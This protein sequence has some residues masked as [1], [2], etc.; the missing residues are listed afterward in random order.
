MT[1]PSA[2]CR[3]GEILKTQKGDF[4]LPSGPSRLRFFTSFRVDFEVIF[5]GLEWF[6]VL[7]GRALFQIFQH[8]LEILWS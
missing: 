2:F 4:I 1:L 5:V 7:C 6:Q 8:R 3:G